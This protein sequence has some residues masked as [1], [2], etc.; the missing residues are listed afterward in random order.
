MKDTIKNFPPMIYGRLFAEKFL[1]DTIDKIL[2]LDTDICVYNEI[3]SLYDM[4][5]DGF[6]CAACRDISIEI[7]ARSELIKRNVRRYFNSGVL[8]LNMS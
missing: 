5:I 7:F 6:Y 2:Y 8:L 4:N 1:P 3:D